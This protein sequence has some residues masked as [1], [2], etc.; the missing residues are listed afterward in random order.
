MDLAEFAS[1]VSGL[2]STGVL[3]VGIWAFLTRKIVPEKSHE[4]AL[5]IERKASER[6]AEIIGKELCEKLSEGVQKG[7]AQGI[8]EGYL[9]VND[10]K[11]RQ[12]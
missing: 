1:I 8:A 7:I 10:S 5:D 11:S 3:I 6:A 12:A 4:E 2:G 9:K